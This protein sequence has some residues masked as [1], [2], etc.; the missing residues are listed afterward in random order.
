MMVWLSLITE[1]RK[2]FT[3]FIK[4]GTGLSVSSGMYKA[5]EFVKVSGRLRDYLFVGVLN[6]F[7][8]LKKQNN[9]W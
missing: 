4:S 9:C 1:R 6:I 8:R 7:L 2:I 3:L 5:E